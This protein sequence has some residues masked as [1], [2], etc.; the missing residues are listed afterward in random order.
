MSSG[1]ERTK[2]T[3]AKD[4]T[5][6]AFSS[7]KPAI[8]ADAVPSLKP[9]VAREILED[10]I[11]PPA[12]ASV[13]HLLDDEAA[14]KVAKK[15]EPEKL[16]RM[17]TEAHPQGIVS[18]RRAAFD[19]T[20]PV[21]RSVQVLEEI[22]KI[23][24]R[25]GSRS[26][27]A[28]PEQ[29]RRKIVKRMDSNALAELITGADARYRA[30]VRKFAFDTIHSRRQVARLFREVT[31]IDP[32]GAARSFI[33]RPDAGKVAKKIGEG[34]LTEMV[35]QADPRYGRLAG[36]IVV[37][38]GRLGRQVF[39][40][41]A[42]R[43]PREGSHMLADLSHPGKAV[44]KMGPEVRA[45]LVTQARP[46]DQGR[47]SEIVF[48]N[49]HLGQRL[50]T[51]RRIAEENQDVADREWN[52][53]QAEA[54]G[55]WAKMLE[56]GRAETLQKIEA[57]RATVQELESKTPQEAAIAAERLELA[58]LADAM[59][60]LDPSKAAGIALNMGDKQKIVDAF[61]LMK[62]ELFTG[63][64][65]QTVQI[66]AKAAADLVEQLPA[67]LL[68]RAVKLMDTNIKNNMMEH[69]SSK[70]RAGLISE[71]NKI[72]REPVEQQGIKHKLKRGLLMTATTLLVSAIDE[73]PIVKNYGWH[74]N[75]NVTNLWLSALGATAIVG[76]GLV[77][78][79]VKPLPKWL[80]R[81]PLIESPNAFQITNATLWATIGAGLQSVIA[82]FL[83]KTSK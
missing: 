24:A 48:G 72:E 67:E 17:L 12:A 41:V 25:E 31:K 21:R 69:L 6:S 83:P 3:P 38:N 32:D 19:R 42:E 18:I 50:E 52:K 8:I 49:G 11:S 56:A 58:P 44:K 64:L 20:Q 68:A 57:T 78:F 77:R 47:L 73:L 63:V 46:Q 74:V 55:R 30:Q 79:A 26:L 39:R 1:L 53:V 7:L 40:E 27:W 13:M 51:Y 15:I 35:A 60:R 43:N 14:A 66:D 80:G 23:D 45:D 71:M 76:G 28:L 9:S 2:S 37:G 81:K 82:P 70:T 65:E 75:Q 62:P 33:E 29:A 22:V 54:S 16:A 61:W 36:R 34:A 5:S 10:R 4:E 59:E